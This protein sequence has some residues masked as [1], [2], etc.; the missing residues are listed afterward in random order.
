MKESG[1][2]ASSLEF[3]LREWVKIGRFCRAVFYTVPPSRCG[4]DTTMATLWAMTTRV[5]R[6]SL[7]PVSSSGY[8]ANQ[9]DGNKEQCAVTRSGDLGLGDQ[10]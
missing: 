2:K 1:Q 6:A 5:S 8:G 4:V 7:S 9:T 3:L 10:P